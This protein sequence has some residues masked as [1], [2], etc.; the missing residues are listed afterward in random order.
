MGSAPSLDAE[1]A[2][3][4]AGLPVESL[5]G[6][7]F[8]RSLEVATR[9]A[10]VE[11]WLAGQA[12]PISDALYQV[13]GSI[14]DR[15]TRHRLLALRRAVFQV[16]IPERRDLEGRV[17]SSLPN[18]LNRS[19]E[20]WLERIRERQQLLAEGER[21]FGAEWG[22]KSQE[23]RAAA[24]QPAFVQGVLLASPDLHAEL[25]R[26]PKDG[27]ARQKLELSLFTFLGRVVMKTSPYSSFTST[28]RG[29]WGAGRPV[30]ADLGPAGRP[31]VSE[32]NLTIVDQL[33]ELATGWPEVRSRLQLRLNPSLTETPDGLLFLAS[34]ASGE[35]LRRLRR[36]PALEVV[37]QAVQRSGAL[38]TGD[39]TLELG[40]LGAE[41]EPAELAAFVDDLIEAGLLE[42]RP[43][44]AGQ[45]RVAL[46][47]E[48]L[49]R[50]PGERAAA[51]RNLLR[52]IEQTVPRF[53]RLPLAE[54]PEVAGQVRN[55]VAAIYGRFEVG[56]PPG[57]VPVKDVFY[58]NTFLEGAEVCC[59]REAWQDALA[60]LQLTRRLAAAFDPLLEGR[61]AAAKHFL[62]R[63]G[64]GGRVKLV[65]Y[66]EAFHREVREAAGG[67]GVGAAAVL[68]RVRSPYAPPGPELAD[69]L[70]LTAA[71]LR[72]AEWLRERPVGADGVRWVEPEGVAERL[73]EL[74][75]LV[76]PAPAMDAYCQ[77][78]I[79]ADGRPTLVLNGL[80]PGAGRQLG[81][82]EYLEGAESVSPPVAHSDNGAPLA[83]T[84]AGTFGSNLNLYR[85]GAPYEISYPGSGSRVPPEQQ[86]ALADLEVE[87]DPETRRLR[88]FSRRLGQPLLP[89]HRG[90]LAHYR[91]PPL[92]RFLLTFFGDGIANP[93]I[94]LWIVRS[95]IL[96]PLD[97]PRRLPAL[98]LGDVVLERSHWMADASH[99]PVR[100]RGQTPFSYFLQ[101]QRW[102]QAEGIPRHCF[103]RVAKF[104]RLVAA[105]AT[106][107]AQPDS[108]YER[109]PLYVDFDNAFSILTFERAVNVPGQ[110]VLVEDAL[111]GPEAALVVAGGRR[112]VSE[113]V[114][115]LGPEE[116]R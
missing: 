63:Y 106:G 16:R 59:S 71:R 78:M 87:H 10:E 36:S 55:A 25:A 89:S 104:N 19:L 43:A 83:V 3:R 6:L 53:S 96:P 74:S 7:R 85:S 50:C 88:L 116:G 92:Y 76:G 8:Q 80:Q 18:E 28:G 94:G 15:P 61:L 11:D 58:E 107:E 100:A 30:Q 2:V 67:A 105:P 24:M 115:G 44:D 112:Y 27:P 73:A 51:L 102:R 22:E 20:L 21:T 12:Q 65:S 60:D 98:Q 110:Q 95:S 75:G 101:V 84:I 49:E 5:A 40:R 90:L 4:V 23:L 52:A 99:L 35:I 77:L 62:G 93:L 29:R 9:L 54:R 13:I 56:H 81:R 72:L 33:T 57:R 31:G 14:T 91:L 37:V 46:L 109:K 70:E 48:I 79:G 108:A 1:F 114:F 47:V 82:L 111:P 42:P 68:Q 45:D 97:A 26:S 39:I 69:L 41:H 66:Y 86:L 64:E 17:W 113:F 38:A 103:V 34:N 32:L